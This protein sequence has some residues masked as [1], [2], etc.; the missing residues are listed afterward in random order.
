MIRTFLSAFCLVIWANV[1]LAADCTKNAVMLRGDWG[2]ARFNID[3]AEDERARAVGLMHRQSMSRSS[4]MLFVYPQPQA[5]TFWMRNTLIPLDMLFIDATGVV[6][7]IHENAI[8]HDETPIPGGTGLA[9]LEINGGM[10]RA[11]GITV[12]SQLRHP[13]FDQDTAAWRCAS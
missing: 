1:A 12:G 11:M 8:P 2:Q 5:L 9:V 7:H 13:S 4:G 6:T 3:L 10:A